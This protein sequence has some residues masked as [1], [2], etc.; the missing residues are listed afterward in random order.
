MA[1]ATNEDDA[2]I[3]RSTIDLGRNLGLGVVA[4]SVESEP[5][6]NR[7][8]ELGCTM[9]QGY[10]LSRAL[11]PGA[12]TLDAAARLAA[13]RRASAPASC[14]SP[15]RPGPPPAHAPDRP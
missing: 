9:A 11:P 13:H 7:L 4:E 15:R 12:G 10:V 5:I 3:V 1:M 14:R 8:H 2:T 6:L